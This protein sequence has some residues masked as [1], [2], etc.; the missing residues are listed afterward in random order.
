[1]IV[2]VAEIVQQFERDANTAQQ[3]VSEEKVIVPW[4]GKSFKSLPLIAQEAEQKSSQAIEKVIEHGMVRGFVTEALLKAWKPNFDGARAKADDTKKIWRW[5]LT[6]TAGVTPITGNWVDTGLSELDQAIALS[7]TAK[8]SVLNNTALI[9]Y[10]TIGTYY[11]AAN[12]TISDRPEGSYAT[13]QFMLKNETY[14]TNGRFVLQ[15]YQE[16]QIELKNEWRRVIDTVN[17]TV[18]VDWVRFNEG[19]QSDSITALMLKN[20]VVN[21][22]KLTDNFLYSGVITNTD[23]M[24]AITKDGLHVVTSRPLNSPT[25]SVSTALVQVENHNNFIRQTWQ[26]LDDSQK[27]WRRVI[28]PNASPPTFETWKNMNPTQA[29][30]VIASPSQ[31]GSIKVGANLSIDEN[32]VLSASGGGSG[33]YFAGKK[34]VCFGDSVTEFGDYPERIKNRLGLASAVNVGFGGCRMSTH[35]SV[36]YTEMSMFKLANTVATQDFTLLDMRAE[37]LAAEGDDNR[38][39][40]ARLKAVNFEEVDYVTIFYGTND[41]ASNTPIGENTDLTSD[42]STFKGSINYAVKRLLEAYPHLKILF[43]TP[44]WRARFVN[45]DG[46]ESDTNPNSIGK[47]LIEYVD[48]IK[49]VA[50]LNKIPTLDMYRNSG[51]NKYNYTLYFTDGLHPTDP[52]GFQHIANKISSS[53]NASF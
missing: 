40:V 45:G 3:A 28:R 31:L 6:S 35:E 34:M 27:V 53:I 51:I 41:W 30:S 46:L 13:R 44:T 42:G 50:A 49:E 47:Y 2:N 22:E 10:K 14:T 18:L 26:N 25:G 16:V 4:Q 9:S 24:N 29:P 5:E 23:D 20:S 48:A 43:V 36:K 7:F 11:G 12:L 17:D 39:A 15:T 37:Q 21:R 33:G 8:D 19:V 52:V 32:G 1:M 38:P